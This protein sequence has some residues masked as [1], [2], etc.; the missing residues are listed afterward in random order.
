MKYLKIQNDGVLDENLIFLMGASTKNNDTSKIGQFGTGLKYSITWLLRNNVAF[1][2]F[3]G[4]RE[5]VIDTAPVNIRSN[6]FDV[7][8]IDGRESSVTTRMGTDWKAWMILRELWCNAIDEGGNTIEE[9][10]DVIGHEGKTTFYIQLIGEIAE[11]YKHWNKYFNNRTPIFSNGEYR[12]YASEG[13]TMKVYRKG[14]LIKEYENTNSVFDYDFVNGYINELREYVGYLDLD[15]SYCF[16]ELD[17]KGITYLIENLDDDKR[18]AKLDLSYSSFRN[19]KEAFGNA[20]I[21]SYE[22]HRV[23]SEMKPESMAESNF[24][25]LPSN[26]YKKLVKDI[27]GISALMTSHDAHT[28]FEV[29]DSKLSE[30]VKQAMAILEACDYYVDAELNF[31]TGI[32]NDKSVLARVNLKD[33]TVMLSTTLRDLGLKELVYAIIEETEHFRTGFSDNTREFQTHFIK[34]YANTL[35][36]S[37]EVK[38]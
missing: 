11:A 27:D 30:N 13:N 20:K 33:R 37:N 31:I 16:A 28:F 5:V 21:I 25:Q 19:W 36:Q 4:G 2:L 6:A 23:L 9:V 17:K 14:I 29:I 1:K 24:V 15:I 18:E 22:S 26:F 35:L 38:L 7:V 3:L 8:R 32:F 12:L 34:L 10:T